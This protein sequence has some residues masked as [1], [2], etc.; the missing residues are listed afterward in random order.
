MSEPTTSELIE[1]IDTDCVRWPTSV[2]RQRRC[3]IAARLTSLQAERD[4]LRKAMDTAMQNIDCPAVQNEG[5]WETGMFC[6]LEDVGIT[7]RYEA[8]RFGYIAAIARVK[9]WVMCDIE[10]ALAGKGK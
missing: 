6:G 2:T 9:E 8:C 5:D 1:W 3:Q 4:G 7:D 10:A